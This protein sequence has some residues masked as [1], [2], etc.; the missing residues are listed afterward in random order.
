MTSTRAAPPRQ[1]DRKYWDDMAVRWDDEIFNSLHH[2][3]YQVIAGEIARSRRG[4]SS[5]A[6][7]GCGTGLY[8]PLLSRSFRVVHGFERSAA[9]VTA[10]RANLKSRPNVAVHSASTASVQRYGAFDVVLCVNVAVHPAAHARESVFRALDALLQPSGRLIL[11]V[12]ALESAEMV[13]DAER[14]ALRRRGSRRRGDWDA[15][16]HANGVVTIE[17]MPYKHYARQELHDTLADRGFSVS[18]IRRAEYSWES[19]GVRPGAEWR[20]TMP[21]DWVLVARLSTRG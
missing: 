10:A 7:F 13:A 17:G 19:Q 2:D 15:A 8:L 3:K 6:D 14:D 4:A 1:Q 21:W 11:V 20:G 12:P 9:C 5:V 16:S 18:R